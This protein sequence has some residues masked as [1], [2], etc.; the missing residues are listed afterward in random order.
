MKKD[1]AKRA[2]FL[3]RDGTI[4]H[5]VSYLHRE[6]DVTL[7]EGVAAALKKLKKAGYLIF[8]VTNQSGVGRGYYT[9]EDVQR[10]HRY[11]LGLLSKD[12]AA[13]DGV[14]VCP[15]HPEE[16]CNCR[17]PSPKMLFDAATQFDLKLA[18]SF[19]IGDRVSDLEAGHRAGARSILVRT[20][21][22]DET[23]KEIG[24]ALPADHVAK[25]L[26]AAINWL[27]KAK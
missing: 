22:G 21:Y 1:Q 13:V 27:L 16:R 25:D 6:Q 24:D 23:V 26:P 7:V 4:I 14:Y 19:M 11:I 3:D 9:T 5:E 10:V 8:I 12:G 15:H 18:D 20:G 2:V 17:K